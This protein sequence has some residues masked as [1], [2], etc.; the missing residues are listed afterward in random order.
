MTLVGTE[1]IAGLNLSKIQ[2]DAL[3]FGIGHINQAAGRVPMPTS[4]RQDTAGTVH[5][6]WNI[7]A[8]RIALSLTSAGA[9]STDVKIEG[10]IEQAVALVAFQVQL[11]EMFRV[12]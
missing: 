9:I 7:G 8:S 6:T 4:I 5:I 1:Q 12:R 11:Q 3:M 10:R 2:A